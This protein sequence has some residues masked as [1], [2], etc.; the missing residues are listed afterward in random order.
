MATHHPVFIIKRM[1][2]FIVGLVITP[3]FLGLWLYFFLIMKKEG[4]PFREIAKQTLGLLFLYAFLM[5]GAILFDQSDKHDKKVR[6]ELW[7]K[8]YSKVEFEGDII[9]IY[10]IG[11]AGRHES[12]M[13]IR[14]TESN[15]DQFYRFDRRQMCLRI[16]DS[17]AIYPLA[18]YKHSGEKELAPFTH[19][20]VNKG[21]NHQ[22]IYSNAAGDTLIKEADYL[23]GALQS[24]ELN[25][26]Y[27][28]K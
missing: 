5:G 6:Q 1:I 21:G 4:K 9:G 25:V 12:V 14:I 20:S 28:C 24:H 23:A 17:L 11:N 10:D 7:N 27:R 26:C 13:C 19:V 2:T 15:T 8:Y 3:V 16:D 18:G 22:M